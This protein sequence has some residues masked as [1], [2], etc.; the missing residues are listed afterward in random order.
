MIAHASP[1]ASQDAPRA[2]TTPEAAL[3][4]SSYKPA[5]RD[6]TSAIC[7]FAREVLHFEPWPRQTEMLAEIDRSRARIVVLRL[8]RRSGKG[9]M[10]ALLGVYE[11][12][13]NAQA[14]R[15]AVL[16]GEQATVAIISNSIEQSRVLHRYV[17]GFLDV[18]GLREL[19]ASDTRDEIELSNGM[20]LAVLPASGRTARGRAICVGIWDEAAHALDGE[21]RV[22]SPMG[23]NELY[24][25]IAPSIWQFPAGKLVVLSTPR[26]S[27]GLFHTLCEQAESGLYPDMLHIHAA[28]QEV[29]PTIT[30]ETLDRERARDPGLWQREYLARFDSGIGALFEAEAVNAAVVRREA[31][32]PAGGTSY[33]TSIDPAYS[34]DSF[35]LAIGHVDRGGRLVV[36]RTA[37]WRGSRGR[38]V[39]HAAVLNEVATWAKAYNRAKV[40][41]DQYAAAP[42]VDGLRERGCYVE[43]IPW[44]N[45]N[46]ILAAQALRQRLYSG[47]VELPDDRALVAEL[48]NLEQRP[49][50][51]GKPRIAAP[52]GSADDRAMALLGLVAAWERPASKAT[53]TVYA[54]MPGRE[55]VVRRGDL[56]WCG[57]DARRH[58]DLPT[59]DGGP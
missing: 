12:T 55:P 7:R 13:A 10:A 46:K 42:I 23:A 5:A 54:D 44:T 47:T 50:P 15:A 35:A 19:V 26:W 4:P 56:T 38:P 17:R 41:T 57:S 9:R 40:V 34:G 20:V 22:L 3:R 37:A 28:T 8:G 33:V 53:Q 32:P 45:E 36:D 58:L 29:N 48:T 6:V 31:L 27:S 51:S 30:S 18:P 2:S 25:A 16:P 1:G 49:T 11:A 59:R 52:C 21:G 39:N 43:A 14:H 24:E